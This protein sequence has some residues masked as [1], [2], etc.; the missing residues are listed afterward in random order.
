MAFQTANIVEFN[1]SNSLHD[2]KNLNAPT[3]GWL[4]SRSSRLWRGA[5]SQTVNPMGM[6]EARWSVMITLKVLGE[7]ASQNSLATEL[8]IEMSSLNRTVNQ[9]VELN[10]VERR[11]HPSDGR[12]HCLWFTPAGK[13]S[14]QTL[15]GAF[16]LV[17]DELTNGIS[18]EELSTLFNVL[19]KIE[20]NACKKLNKPYE[21]GK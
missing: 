20:Y 7:G 1:M 15:T 19:K 4:L 13:V 6:T 2:D 11:A 9:L 16:N 21:G 17:R 14:I 5:I 10:L 8:G 12:C 3:I 18:D